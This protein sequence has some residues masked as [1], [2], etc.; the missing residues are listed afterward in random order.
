ML[1]RQAGANAS[2]RAT[3][4][5][6]F[7]AIRNR[8]GAIGTYSMNSNGDVSIAPFVISR[9]AGGKLVPFRFVQVQG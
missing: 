7:F 2:D 8:A 1:L 4:V 9:S 6:D 5:H 3:V